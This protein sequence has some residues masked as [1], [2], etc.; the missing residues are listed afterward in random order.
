[1]KKLFKTI[2][3]FLK[4]IVK[5]NI[6]V[7]IYIYVNNQWIKIDVWEL[8]KNIEAEKNGQITGIQ[9]VRYVKKGG[10]IFDSKTRDESF[11]DLV[12]K[13]NKV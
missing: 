11:A 1:M 8:K 12:K 2:W 10:D 6:D 7:D 13:S 4:K 5:I 9:K 3:N